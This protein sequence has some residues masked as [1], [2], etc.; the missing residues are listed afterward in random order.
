MILVHLVVLIKKEREIERVCSE[1]GY[2]MINHRY[3]SSK[4]V[5]LISLKNT[6]SHNFFSLENQFFWKQCS[7]TSV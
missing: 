4:T 7:V 3:V 1:V 5:P 2:K 6:L